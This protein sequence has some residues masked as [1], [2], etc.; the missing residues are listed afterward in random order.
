MPHDGLGLLEECTMARYT[1]HQ[2]RFSNYIWVALFIDNTIVPTM[3]G[4]IRGIIDGH[5]VNGMGE[6]R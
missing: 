2:L 5:V 1:F 3:L 4:E 6:I